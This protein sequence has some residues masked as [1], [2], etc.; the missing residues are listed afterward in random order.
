MPSDG[1]HDLE[2]DVELDVLAHRVPDGTVLLAG[3]VDGALDLI[4]GKI[5]DHREMEID[6]EES[7]GGLAMSDGL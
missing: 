2:G 1:G 6:R 4:R 3:Q 5:A 7:M